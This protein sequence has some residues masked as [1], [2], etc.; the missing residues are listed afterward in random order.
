[1]TELAPNNTIF[2]GNS[3]TNP[4]APDDDNRFYLPLDILGT[5]TDVHGQIL[6]NVLDQLFDY[7]PFPNDGSTGI[8]VCG[9][10]RSDCEQ[11]SLVFSTELKDLFI[12]AFVY[13]SIQEQIDFYQEC[14]DDTTT[15]VSSDR[16][17]QPDPTGPLGICEGG[18]FNISVTYHV[19]N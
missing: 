10:G 14:I 17:G 1:M 7:V 13:N 18:K 9:S 19:L 6:G 16:D 15:Q 5:A 12:E 11:G 2:S 8:K 3:G 4:Y